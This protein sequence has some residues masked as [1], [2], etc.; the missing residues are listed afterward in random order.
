MAQVSSKFAYWVRLFLENKYKKKY[1]VQVNIIKTTRCN[2]DR[3]ESP[4]FVVEYEVYAPAS[5]VHKAEIYSMDQ[6][7]AYME[8]A[9]ENQ[10][11]KCHL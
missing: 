10:E 7:I 5:Q 8:K 6:L 4:K 11:L 2:I 1:Q 3:Y 9:I